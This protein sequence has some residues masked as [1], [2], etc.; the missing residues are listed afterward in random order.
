MHDHRANIAAK[1]SE[2]ELAYLRVFPVD[3]W[4][5]GSPQPRDYAIREARDLVAPGALPTIAS[6][7][8]ATELSRYAA[9]SWRFESHLPSLPGDV[10]GTKIALHRVLRLTGG[11]ALGSRRIFDVCAMVDEFVNAGISTESCIGSGG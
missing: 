7:R 11:Q 9:S 2:A 4:R 6:K 3:T 10:G 8:L 5:P 1:L